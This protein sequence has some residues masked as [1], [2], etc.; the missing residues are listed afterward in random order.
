[1]T[2]LF[3]NMFISLFTFVLWNYLILV[4]YTSDF[5]SFSGQILGSARRRRART[6]VMKIFLVHI[7]I[8]QIQVVFNTR[9][10]F[11]SNF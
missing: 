11:T 10:A 5:G 1:M 4:V 6:P 3:F 2:F 8:L 9:I 7:N